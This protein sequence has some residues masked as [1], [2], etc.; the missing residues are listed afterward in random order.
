MNEEES[1]KC[2]LM[3]AICK[4]LINTEYEDLHDAKTDIS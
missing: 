1:S 3:F 2:H 4:V